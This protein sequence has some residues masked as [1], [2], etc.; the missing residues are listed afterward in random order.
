MKAFSP[1][2]CHQRLLD[3]ARPALAY[4]PGVDC[5]AWR[6]AL[7]EK[8][9]ELVGLMP[10]RLPLR[11]RMEERQE[12]EGYWE[13]RFVFRA[14]VGAA[15][16][17]HLLVPKRARRPPPVMICLQG[18]STG[19]HISLGRPRYQ[20]DEASIEGGRDF[21]RQAV[22]EGFAA[23]VLEQRCF[24]ERRDARPRWARQIKHTCT[25]AAMAALLL[26]RTMIGE[27][28]WDVCRAIDTLAE[29]PEVDSSRVA[30]MGN[31]GGGTITYYAA[32]LEPRIGAAMPSCA[33]CT[34]RDSIGRIDH[35]V[36]NYLP[37]ALRYFEM[38][39]LAGLIAPRPLVVVA[40]Q[41]DGIFP[42]PGVE[43]SFHTIQQVYQAAG[44]P[45][46]CRLVVG[47]EGH[48]FYPEQA[49][50]VFREVAGW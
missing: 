2:R 27:R 15:V 49:W 43:A 22:Q 10:R 41:H 6:T 3:A 9:R 25:H 5:A 33:V 31:S 16:P 34:Y 37:G 30:C 35:C 46:R 13:R 28:V 45:G 39:D 19:M 4:A 50:P 26:G 14:E 36:D 24:G 23:L 7:G 29:F 32:C 8:L 1:H 40:G 20:G 21:A 11:L 47:P 17:C 38:G 12:Q 44:Q 18:H 42:L 48:R